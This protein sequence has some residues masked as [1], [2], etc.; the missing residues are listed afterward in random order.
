M[1]RSALLA[2]A[3]LFVSVPST[4]WADEQAE[5]QG[6]SAETA[7]D[8]AEIIVTARKKSETLLTAP[9]AISAFTDIAIKEAGFANLTDISLQA[10][11][12]QFNQQGGQEPG[13]YNTQL[14]FRGMNTSQFSPSFATG[15]L[16]VD[17]VYVL[18]GGTSLSLL[19]LD[20]VEVIK[21][22][23]SAQ[24][25]RN[26]F[27]GAVNFITHRPSLTDMKVQLDVLGS[28]RERFDIQAQLEGPL[29][30]DVLSASISGRFYSKRGEYTTTDGG[31]LGNEQTKA[32]T[33]VLNLEP[34]SNFS[35]RFRGTYSED[36][37]GAPAGGFIDGDINDSCSGKTL[38]TPAGETVSP[39]RYVCG[40]LPNAANVNTLTG[41]SLYSSNTVLARS[42]AQ[43]AVNVGPTYITDFYKAQPLPSGIPTIDYVG[44]IRNS[45]RLS[46]IANFNTGGFNFDLV[47]GLN[48][49][50]VNWI[51]DAD[52]T[53]TF[54]SFQSDPQKID[55]RSVEFRI[56]SPQT[57]PIRAMMGVNY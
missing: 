56:S 20:R 31:R 8:P 45:L 54:G 7:N 30:R 40:A 21:G 3:V 38:T 18:N 24:F 46:A 25:G 29:I 2:S 22:P 35:A 6:S 39:K 43:G 34:S 4:A 5:G 23:Q 55:D 37:D 57:K 50:R 10:P 52:L 9:V 17:G 11:G 32:V 33:G 26:T 27:G 47:L 53:D 14:R 41:Q 13:R 44:L 12:F 36:R 28:T 15:A 42:W 1:F 48:Q 49:Q 51:R 16:F 19:D